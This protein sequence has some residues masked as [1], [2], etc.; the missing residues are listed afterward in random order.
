M[1]IKL[2]DK[3]LSNMIAAGEVVERPASAVKEMIENSVDAG[4]GVVTVEI[5]GG[6]L[7]MIKVTDNGCGIHPEDASAAFMRHATSKISKPQDLDA[8]Y[9]LGFRGEAL[10]SIAAVAEVELYTRTAEFEVGMT[11]SANY[12]EIENA[13]ETPGFVGTS[14]KVTNLFY[15]T[16]ARLKFLKRES[17]EAGYCEEA[18]RKTA[19]AHPEVSFRF[20]SDGKEKLFT[21]GDGILKNTIFTLY[22]K[23]TLE[24]MNE[25]SREDDGIKVTGFVSDI[26]G[27]KKTRSMQMFFVNNRPVVSKMMANAV[28]EA[29]KGMIP[30]GMHP[31]AIVKIAIPATEV[32]INVH[33]A[34]LEVKFSDEGRIYRAIYHAAKNS[35][36]VPEMPKIDIVPEPVPT[37]ASVLRPEIKPEPTVMKQPDIGYQPTARPAVPI[38]NQQKFVP[39]F[40]KATKPVVMAQPEKVQTKIEDEKIADY[41]IVGQIFDT[42]ILVERGDEML[43]VDQHAAH[44]H[45]NF[46]RLKEQYDEGKVSSQQLLAAK[47]VN[48]SPIEKATLS[49]NADLLEQMGFECEDFGGNSVMVRG[50]PEAVN[51][52]KIG[53]VLSEI[54][55]MINNHKADL[56]TERKMKML[57]TMSCRGSIKAG[58]KLSFAEMQNLVQKLFEIEKTVNCPHGRPAIVAVSKDFVEKQFCRIK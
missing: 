15:N 9:T 34:K 16:P 44:E 32:D 17:T 4:A 21:P 51:P 41:R 11:A 18:V 49:E 19:L 53:D 38:V 48:L 7:K 46:G 14:I 35:F 3:N 39:V 29:C 20:I 36:A 56:T 2:L 24:S 30:N 58:K 42:Y 10:A 27:A 45:I 28:E 52:E 22:G 40:K 6:G 43:L 25:F 33:P 37:P 47:S 50:V 13:V 26:T 23:S 12:G 8:I 1:F 55:E 5:S 57:E 54:L 31:A